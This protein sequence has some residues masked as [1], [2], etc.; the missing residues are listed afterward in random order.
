MRDLPAI[1]NG[2]DVRALRDRDENNPRDEKILVA[3]ASDGG[4]DCLSTDLR[5]R[6]DTEVVQQWIKETVRQQLGDQAAGSLG[7]E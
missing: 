1:F 6:V 5:S 2:S 4:A 7:I 3:V